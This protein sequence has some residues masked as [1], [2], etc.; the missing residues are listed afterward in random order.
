MTCNSCSLRV[1]PSEMPFLVPFV[2][3]MAK[4]SKAD[5]RLDFELNDNSSTSIVIFL[6][7]FVAHWRQVGTGLKY[8]GLCVCP[9]HVVV[10]WV[11]MRTQ[12]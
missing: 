7:A 5:W 6:L 12:V 8:D 3:A 10:R 4:T 2:V 11:K 9:L 1:D